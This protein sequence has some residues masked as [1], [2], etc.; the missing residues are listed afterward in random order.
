MRTR[1]VSSQDGRALASTFNIKYIETSV[2]INHHVDE[3]L[4]GALAQIRLK[5]KGRG[6]ITW[7]PS[8]QKASF[9]V[10]RIFRRM[11]GKDEPPAPCDIL[12][13]L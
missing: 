4:V 6:K 13:A 1:L 2:G 12:N 3:L 7:P 5:Q 10:R 8:F 11:I 9:R